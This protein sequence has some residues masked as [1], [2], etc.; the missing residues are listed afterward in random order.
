MKQ[1]KCP[2]NQIDDNCHGSEL[3]DFLHR[4]RTGER[5]L[6]NIQCGDPIRGQIGCR[7]NRCV[8]IADL[9]SPNCSSP[10]MNPATGN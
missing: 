6:N 10:V 4:Q 5:L 2:R 3:I 1:P 7:K 9:E 8:F